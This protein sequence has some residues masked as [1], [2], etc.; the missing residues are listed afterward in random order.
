VST[1]KIWLDKYQRI[2]YNKKVFS[3]LVDLGLKILPC[4]GGSVLVVTQR[5]VYLPFLFYKS[6][7]KANNK[8][9]FHCVFKERMFILRKGKKGIRVDK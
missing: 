6:L 9:E 8:D 2:L 4:G 3:I 7:F 1:E 5:E